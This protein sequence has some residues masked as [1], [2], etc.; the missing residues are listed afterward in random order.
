MTDHI[1]GKKARLIIALKKKRFF[2]DNADS[3]SGADAAI[4]M[5][6]R[7]SRVTS[8]GRKTMPAGHK[9]V[10]A[11]IQAVEEK[12]RSIRETF[13]AM[14]IPEDLQPKSSRALK[15]L[16]IEERIRKGEQAEHWETKLD[17]YHFD[18]N[19]QPLP[20]NKIN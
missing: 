20:K 7:I 19:G 16:N 6:E 15:R 17:N 13:N 2:R 1:N 12:E 3:M 4:A 10:L 14:G 11:A 5:N 18:S 9:T 8:E